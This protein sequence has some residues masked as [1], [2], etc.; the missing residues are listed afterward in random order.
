MT[1]FPGKLSWT[2]P[3]R[4]HKNAQNLFSGWVND[5][6]NQPEKP[7]SRSITLNPGLLEPRIETTL[8]DRLNPYLLEVPGGFV[9]K[10]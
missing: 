4:G 6:L 1:I 5:L 7:S 9:K 2:P 8:R 3:G 10:L